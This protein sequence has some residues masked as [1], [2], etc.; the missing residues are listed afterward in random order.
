MK[1]LDEE[2][3]ELERLGRVRV[4]RVVEGAQ[5][6]RIRIDGQ[7][8][9][10]FSSNDYLGL[11]ADEVL[12]R[13][14]V[15]EVERAGV[16]AGASRLIA[17]NQRAHAE[18]EAE[19]ASW[20]GCESARLFSSGYAA[21][22]GLLPVLAGEGDAIYSD[23]LNHA[24]IIDGCRLSRATVEVYRHRGYDD[25]EARLDRSRARRRIIVTESVFSMDGDCADLERLASLAARFDAVLVVDEAHA[26]GVM[27]EQGGGL[28]DGSGYRADVVVGTL[29]K[30]L[31]AAGAC[32][33]G[34]RNLA[35]L[36]WNR[37]RSLVFSTGMPA[38][39]AAAAT[40]GIR[41]VRGP[42]GA[43]RRERLRRNIERLGMG[44]TP[45]APVIVGDDR[46]VM[47]WTAY[48]L[49]RGL[50]VQGIRPPTVPA[51]TARLRIA[52]SAMHT[53][54]DID[55]LLQALEDG[56]RAG[57]VSRETSP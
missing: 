34:P 42:E 30:A 12:R 31:G 38:V 18:L 54:E 2:M 32:V 33:G 35:D 51:G 1:F 8:V 53:N 50:Y 39:I 23:E 40:E 45:I 46:L 37:A 28:L 49:E 16:G 5:G 57:L 36:L 27:G 41:L 22:T 15:A 17:G 14:V 13:A 6:T 56:K 21:N 10:S 11:A 43:S 3:A 52:L 25:L 24:S 4:P 47:R 26:V 44:Q 20:L 55:R 19:A 7:E 29:G 48:L 9:V